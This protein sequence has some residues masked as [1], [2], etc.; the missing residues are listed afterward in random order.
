M[1]KVYMFLGGLI[2]ICIVA[3]FFTSVGLGGTTDPEPSTVKNCAW[4]IFGFSCGIAFFLICGGVKA[5]KDNEDFKKELKKPQ[6]M[7]VLSRLTVEAQQMVTN[8]LNG[9]DANTEVIIAPEQQPVILNNRQAAFAVEIDR[10]KARQAAFAVE[11]DR[12][13][14]R[15]AEQKARQAELK[16][17]R[18]LVEMTGNDNYL[19]PIDYNEKNEAS[20]EPPNQSKPNRLPPIEKTQSINQPIINQAQIYLPK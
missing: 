8:N 1:D 12:Q 16:Q 11:I 18:R 4:T 6:N 10:Q 15:Q 2:C 17:G 14:A 20:N 7:Q 13:K 19:H 9:D 5:Y 3:I